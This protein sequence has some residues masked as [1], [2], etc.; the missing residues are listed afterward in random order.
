MVPLFTVKFF[1]KLFFFIFYIIYNVFSLCI[2]NFRV[3]YKF[4]RVKKNS[5]KRYCFLLISTTK[6]FHKNILKIHLSATEQVFC[7][8]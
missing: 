7:R 6:K 8:S 3:I 4:L 2:P 5:S 1:L